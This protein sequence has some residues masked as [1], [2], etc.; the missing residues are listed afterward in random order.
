MTDSPASPPSPRAEERERDIPPAVYPVEW[1]TLLGFALTRAKHRN[2]E[3]MTVPTYAVESLLREVAALTADRERMTVVRRNDLGEPMVTAI[4]P[5]DKR[6]ATDIAGRCMMCGE[7]MYGSEGTYL[8]TLPA[9]RS[10][11]LPNKKGK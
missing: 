5:H 1:A 9:A 11:A 7:L 4:C 6:C 10:S 8:A 3:E 2:E